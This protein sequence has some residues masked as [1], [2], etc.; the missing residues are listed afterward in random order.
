MENTPEMLEA[1]YATT[2][3]SLA[4]EKSRGKQSK[5]CR[6]SLAGAVKS[7]TH[8]LRVAPYKS[9]ECKNTA[10]RL[11]G[12]LLKYTAATCGPAMTVWYEEIWDIPIIAEF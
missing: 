10:S 12:L 9:R 1:T 6:E 7:S 8:E 2:S 11:H 4:W 5:K 3:G